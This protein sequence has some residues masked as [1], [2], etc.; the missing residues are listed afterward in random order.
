MLV[1]D[2]VSHTRFALDSAKSY[3]AWSCSTQIVPIV[4]SKMLQLVRVLLSSSP[5][6]S[7]AMSSAVMCTLLK[8]PPSSSRRNEVH[9]GVS[10][11]WG[12]VAECLPPPFGASAARPNL[13]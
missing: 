2:F 12:L 6:I 5:T 11:C 7:M 4:S 10:S 3:A 9:G 13:K 1:Q 8:S